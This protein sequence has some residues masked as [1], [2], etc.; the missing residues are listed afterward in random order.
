LAMLTAGADLEDKSIEEL[1]AMDA[2]EFTMGNSKVEIAQVNAIDIEK[3]YERQEEFEAEIQKVV[4]QKGIDLFL[5]MVTDTL[6]SNS[7]VLAMAEAEKKVEKAIQVQLAE[8]RAS[9]DGVVARKKTE[10]TPRDEASK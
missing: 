8:H 3:V 6:N 1:I 5:L 4:E 2:K 9:L 10:D 7:E